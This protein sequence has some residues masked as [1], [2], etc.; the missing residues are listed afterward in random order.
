VDEDTELL[1]ESEGEAEAEWA[2]S[3]RGRTAGLL[4]DDGDPEDEDEFG[5]DA[6]EEDDSA[7]GDE[8]EFGDEEDVDEEA[9]EDAC[10]L[11]RLEAGARVREAE[12][13]IDADG[14]YFIAV[15]LLL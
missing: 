12:L 7:D 4:S 13:D 3:A 8:D 15:E 14:A 1:C 5:D 2:K 10:P 9:D 6:E 11:D